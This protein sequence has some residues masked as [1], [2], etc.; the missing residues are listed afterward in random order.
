MESLFAILGA[1][2]L[3]VGV[4][5]AGPLS[6]RLL[7][8]PSPV[9][10]VAMMGLS[11]GTLA[12]T[13]L[14]HLLPEASGDHWTPWAAVCAGFLSLMLVDILVGGADRASG[15]LSVLV[16]V[17]DGLHNLVGGFAV[18]AAFMLDVGLGWMAWAGAVAHE[19]PQ[20][21]GD[22]AILIGEGMSTRQAVGW[23]AL[24]ASAFPLAGLATWWWAGPAE[25]HGMLALAAGQFLYLAA[26]LGVRL[27]GEE[28]LGFRLLGWWAAAA[29]MGLIGWLGHGGHG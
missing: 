8:G 15:R 12:G 16:L 26:A 6:L 2:L 24:S 9:W 3:M 10:L 25:V 22:H 23:N 4:V 28:R 13:S 11:A 18:A 19:V 17:G 20:E 1:G 7:G 27:A 5:L 21:I 14:F 29:G